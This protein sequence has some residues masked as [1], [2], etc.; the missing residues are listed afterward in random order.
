MDEQYYDWLTPV[1]LPLDCDICVVKL[2]D[3]L[4][5]MDE[6]FA[7]LIDQL[8]SFSPNATSYT[9]L[10]KL[11]DAIADTKVPTT[12]FLNNYLEWL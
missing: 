6:E 4:A 10:E 1:S 12:I 5:A 2:M 7:R 3:D 9:G 11:E 8:G